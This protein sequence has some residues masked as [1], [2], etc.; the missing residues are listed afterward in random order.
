MLAEARFCLSHR[1]PPPHDS[2]SPVYHVLAELRQL[3]LGGLRKCL[4]FLPALPSRPALPC[5]LLP[6]PSPGKPGAG[7][8]KDRLCPAGFQVVPGLQ[9]KRRLGGEGGG[10]GRP[11]TEVLPGWSGS[12]PQIR[13]PGRPSD[14]V[15]LGPGVQLCLI[16]DC[17]PQTQEPSRR[18]N[19]IYGNIA[20]EASPNCRKELQGAY[21]ALCRVSPHRHPQACLANT[22]GCA[23]CRGH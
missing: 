13:G 3:C 19:R 20:P 4:L 9:G 21:C 10:K 5:L 8:H 11:G 18:K 22:Q 1:P 6:P 16:A 12:G 17:K 14:S 15:G 2:A 23:L 7:G